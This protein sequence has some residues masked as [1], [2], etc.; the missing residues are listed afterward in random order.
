MGALF[1]VYTVADGKSTTMN[2]ND[3]I[4][5]FHDKSLNF[6]NPDLIRCIYIYDNG[7]KSAIVKKIES[8]GATS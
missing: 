2:F 3:I 8:V 6:I 4:S 5:T 7:V 1:N